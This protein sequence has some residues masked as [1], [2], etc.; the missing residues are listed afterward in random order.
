MRGEEP[1]ADAGVG[2]ERAL[3]RI[4]DLFAK[5]YAI[6]AVLGQGGFGAVY[7]ALDTQLER[8]V[9]VKVLHRGT[10]EPVALARFLQEARAAASLASE[11][12]AIVHE[13]GVDSAPYLVMEL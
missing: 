3:P 7:R 1:T 5:R 8:P 4:G 10:D 12:V 2:T 9:A 6:E 13:V 11:H